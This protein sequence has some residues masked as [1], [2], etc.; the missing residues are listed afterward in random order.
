M[1]RLFLFSAVLGEW[2]ETDDRHQLASRKTKLAPL[3][4]L[5]LVCRVIYRFF[6]AAFTAGPGAAMCGPSLVINRFLLRNHSA[7]NSTL[8]PGYRKHD[9]WVG[10]I[11]V[12]SFD[13]LSM[14]LPMEMHTL[15]CSGGTST[16]LCHQLLLAPPPLSFYSP[17][18]PPPPHTHLF[19]SCH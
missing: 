18:L 6:Q 13:R 15:P 1:D 14:S 19:H 2:P 11:Y 10:P 9:W 16:L 5:F 17:L 8:F 3:V 4:F 7:L 12:P